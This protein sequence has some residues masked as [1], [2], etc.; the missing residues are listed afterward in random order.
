[1][2]QQEDNMRQEPTAEAGGRGVVNVISTKKRG[3]T[4]LNK[5]RQR[6]QTARR[7]KKA[8]VPNRIAAEENKEWAPTRGIGSGGTPFC[9][10]SGQKDC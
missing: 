4:N 5:L 9:L 10:P 6:L 3:S 7:G 8:G 1:M 2:K